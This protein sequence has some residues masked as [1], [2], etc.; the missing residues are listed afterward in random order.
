MP[1]HDSS[2]QRALPAPYQSPWDALRRDLPAAAA[3]LRLRAREL[4]R[5]NRE[6]DLSAPGF[7]PEDLTPLFWPLALVSFVLVL[8]LGVVQLQGAL[9]GGAEVPAPGVERLRTTP[10]PEARA[11]SADPEPLPDP[12]EEPVPSPAQ[13]PLEQGPSTEADVRP[14]TPQ[15]DTPALQV[16]PLLSLLADADGDHSIPEGLLLSAHPVPDRNSAVLVLD[17]FPWA[18]LSQSSRQDLAESWW[19]TLSDQGFDAIVL[20]DPDRQLLARP[21]RVGG[22]MIMFDPIHSP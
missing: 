12:V 15:K 4:W 6:G 2:E 13:Q 7:W 17:P 10:L 1:E 20:E 14:Q 22:G 16:D 8:S 18:A 19:Q 3:D 9:T 5:R 21:A 11:L